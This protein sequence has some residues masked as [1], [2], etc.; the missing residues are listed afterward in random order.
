M[1]LVYDYPEGKHRR[2]ATREDLDV[3]LRRLAGGWHLD[4]LVYLSRY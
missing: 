3:Q 2:R 1:R 4:H